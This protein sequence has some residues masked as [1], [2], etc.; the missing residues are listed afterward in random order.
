MPA[1]GQSDQYRTGIDG[2]LL[3]A[4]GLYKQA[5]IRQFGRRLI[6]IEPEGFWVERDEAGAFKAKERL[7]KQ[8]LKLEIRYGKDFGS[9]CV[10]F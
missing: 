9:R 3:T 5:D 4:E 6:Q 10:G 7:C 1:S 8:R 2:K